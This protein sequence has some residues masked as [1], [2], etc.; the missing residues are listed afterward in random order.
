MTKLAVS[1]IQ[2][3]K[4][5]LHSSE[6]L[7]STELYD[8]LHKYRS[9]Q[10][11]DKFMDNERKKE[12]EE[13]FKRLNSLLLELAN[14]IEQEKLN[15]NP[16]EIIPFQKDYEIVKSKQELINNEETIKDLLRTKQI[17]DSEIKALKIQ[18]LKLQGD[19]ADEKATDLIKHY[20]P[21]KR[22]LL[23]QG[24]TFALT[25]TISVLTKVEEVAGILTKYFPFDPA[26]LNYIIFSVLV[27]IPLRF[28]MRYF[29]E[30]RI[31]NT[32]KKI[33]TPLFINKFMKY[34][35]EKNINDTFTELNVYEFLSL[36]LANKKFLIKLFQ[37]NIFNLYSV[38]TI[39]SL[40]DIFIYNL[41]NKQLISI[42]TAEQ[43][44]R[45]F[46]IAKTYNYSLQYY[47]LEDLDF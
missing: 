43:L 5:E 11:P 42:S 25:F 3:V 34:L 10:H 32:S 46:K 12:A 41:L 45:K 2:K 33:R 35:T 26:Y 9:S 47:D 31:E 29:K 8:L 20:K 21:T 18:I 28:F 38:T 14:L 23:S 1:I 22:S 17:K 40:K 15:K 6:D 44:E 39:D 16:S 37:S 30:G 7:N 36:E 13:K 27:F 4:D 24:I 19:K